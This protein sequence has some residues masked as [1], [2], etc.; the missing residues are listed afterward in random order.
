MKPI[1]A[2]LRKGESDRVEFKESLDDEALESISAFANSKGGTVLIGVSDKGVVKGIMTGKETLRNWAN[3]IAQATRTHVHFQRVSVDSKTVI[4]IRVDESAVKPLPCRGRY[5]VRVGNSNRQLTEDDITRMVLKKI[6]ASWDEIIEPRA[7]WSDLDPTQI[8]TFRVMCNK[9]KRRPIPERESDKTVLEKLKLTE[10]GKILR[11]A[12]LLF[13]KDPQRFYPSSLVK[14]GRFRPGNVIA[15]DK[16]IR[17]SLF[18]QVEEIM[19]YFREHLQTRF[20]FHGQP[21]RDVIWEYPLEALREAVTNSVCHR[22]YLDY[23]NT[24]VRWYDE[25]IVVVNPGELLP[26]LSPEQLKINHVSRPRNRKIAEMFYYA[27]S[28]ERWGG[29]TTMIVAECKKAGLPEP[30]F[31]EKQGCLWVTFKKK[32]ELFDSSQAPLI[33]PTKRRPSTDQVPT[34]YRPS[35]DQ[36]ENEGKILRFCVEARGIKEIMSHMRISHRFTFRHNY[37]KPLLKKGLLMMTDSQSPSSPRQ[38]YV[39]T[40]KGSKAISQ[41]A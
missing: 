16:E 15:D 7:T 22:D 19:V 6:G 9:K 40:E 32:V 39:T 28:I 29:G 27:G 4:V 1:N 37:L 8:E 25:N 21:A 12:I 14:I 5:F 36:V 24:Q 11:G 30:D 41:E 26:P 13:G 38:K 23:A 18:T 2:L 35:T 10:N 3:Q 31:E 34:K 17:G 20:E 33:S